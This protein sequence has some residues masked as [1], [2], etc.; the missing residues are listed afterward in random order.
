[1][2]VKE[3]Q[4]QKRERSRND[5]ANERKDEVGRMSIILYCQCLWAEEVADDEE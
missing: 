1:M 5:E 3:T 2:E 4:G